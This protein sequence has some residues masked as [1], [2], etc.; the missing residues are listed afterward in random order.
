M[1]DWKEVTLGDMITLQ[2]GHDLPKAKMK[3]GKIPVAGSNGIIGYHDEPTTKGIGVTIGRSGNLGNAYL[4]KSA[5]WAHNT[6]LYVKD[7]KLNDEL[8]VYYFLKNIDFKSFNVGSAVPTLNRN[9]I[10]PIPISLPPLPEQKAIAEVLSS[11]DDKIDLLHRQN[12]TLEEM[13]EVL[14]RQWF[15]EEA[16]EDWEVVKLSNIS[17]LIAGGDKPKGFSPVKTNQYSIPI[18][19]NGTKD[20][21]LYGYTDI[22]RITHEAVTVSARGTIGFVCLRTSPFLPIVRL[23]TVIPNKEY[24][25]AKYLYLWLKSQ[26]IQG[27]GTTQQQLTIPEFKD[28][29]IRVPD[30]KILGLFNAIV[31]EYYDKINNNQQQIRTLEQ[32]RDTL[33]PK[34]MSGAVRVGEFNGF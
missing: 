8:F 33:L 2:R 25:S 21:G 15:I 12:K 28:H 26:H 30:P 6:T 3:G 32:L 14:F 22:A 19:S 29:P 24:I 27:S 20:Y 4:Y 34:L 31:D 7:F 13:A 11:L 16:G 9:H 23:I 1:S 17:T 18:Y 5:F 10:H